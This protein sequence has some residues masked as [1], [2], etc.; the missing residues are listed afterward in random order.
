MVLLHLQG[1]ACRKGDGHERDEIW[2]D[3]VL[4]WLFGDDEA[5]KKE[6]VNKIL[7]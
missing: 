5:G 7:A 1:P 3:N 4:Q 6:L 2:E